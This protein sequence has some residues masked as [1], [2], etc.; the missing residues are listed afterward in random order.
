MKSFVI[1]NLPVYI[2]THILKPD[3]KIK[4]KSHFK[5][6]MKGHRLAAKSRVKIECAEK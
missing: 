5:Q 1:S 3:S 4:R 6:K 2:K